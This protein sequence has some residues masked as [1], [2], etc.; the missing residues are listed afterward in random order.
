MLVSDLIIGEPDYQKIS[1]IRAG[2]E[3]N[4]PEIALVKRVYAV[5]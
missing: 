5:Y 1:L 4:H 2:Y 3:P